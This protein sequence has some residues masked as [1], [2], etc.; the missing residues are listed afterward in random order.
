MF[1]NG[2]MLISVVLNFQTLKFDT[3]NDLPYTLFLPAYTAAAWYHQRLPGDADKSLES[4]LAEARDFAMNKYL[5]ALFKGDSLPEEERAEILDQLHR[6]TGLSKEYLEQ[7]DLRVVIYKFVKE[8]RRAE[9]ITIGR[10]DS[11]YVGIDRDWTGA[12]FEYDPSYSAIQG[13]YTAAFNEY[14]RNEL[15]FESDLAYNI[16]APLYEKWSYKEFENKYTDVTESL[17][18]AMTKNPALKVFV[19]NGYYDFATPFFATE[20]TFN[21]LGL[22]SRLRSHIQMHYYEAGHMMYLHRPSLAQLKQDLASFIEQT[23]NVE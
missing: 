2:V 10:L 22:D 14:V 23:S 18:A 9:R 4:I 1:L 17:R 5:L 7:T 20:Y 12:Q 13:P 3:M 6:F 16:L 15:N 19:A 21:H 11:R 8:L